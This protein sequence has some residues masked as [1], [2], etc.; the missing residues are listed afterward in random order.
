MPVA[1]HGPGSVPGVTERLSAQSRAAGDH[2]P[3]HRAALPFGVFWMRAH[4]LGAEPALTEAAKVDGAN[5][6][7]TLG[8]IHVPL[9]T[10]G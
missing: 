10:P 3:P 4:F 7:Q 5:T 8:R 9:A 1:G 6:W 2:P